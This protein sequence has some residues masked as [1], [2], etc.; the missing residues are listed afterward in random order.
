MANTN[1][2]NAVNIH[3]IIKQANASGWSVVRK[4]KSYPTVKCEECGARTALQFERN[5]KLTACCFRC[6]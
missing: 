5:G 6:K 1:A 2:N 4:G 3:R